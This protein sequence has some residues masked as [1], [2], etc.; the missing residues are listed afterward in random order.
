[1]SKLL[2]CRLGERPLASAEMGPDRLLVSVEGVSA[3]G[4]GGTSGEW[5]V[6]RQQGNASSGG[7]MKPTG[8][9]AGDAL[10]EKPL[11]RCKVRFFLGADE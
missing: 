9:A 10:L 6:E 1:M 4:M 8:W 11:D 5:G 2:F 7:G 3:A